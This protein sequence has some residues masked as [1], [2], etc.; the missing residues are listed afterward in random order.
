MARNRRA[1]RARL[2]LLVAL[3]SVLCVGLVGLATGSS[4]A[5]ATAEPTGAISGRVTA[6]PGTDLTSTFVYVWPG[7]SLSA[8]VAWTTAAADGTYVVEGLAPGSYVV[9]FQNGPAGLIGQYWPGKDDYAQ[10]GHVSVDQLPVTGIDAS[11]RMGATITGTIHTNSDCELEY[12]QVAVLASGVISPSAI[13]SGDG[14]WTVTG[15]TSG[16]YWVEFDGSS[17]GLPR[18]LWDGYGPPGGRSLVTLTEGQTTSGI[19]VTLNGPT[20]GCF[21]YPLYVHMVYRDLLDRFADPEG[22]VGWARALEGGTPLWAVANGITGSDEYRG[23]LIDETY[24]RYLGRGAEPAGLAGWL[25]A[26]RSGYHIEQ[27][28]AG[29]IASDEFYVR[30]GSTPTGWVTGLYQTVLLRDPA[31]QEVDAWVAALARGAS[32]TDVAL[33]FLYSSEHLAEVVDGYYVHLLGRHIDATGRAGWVG[34][35]QNGHRDEEIIAGIVA[36]PEYL[37]KVRHQR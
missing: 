4:A 32:R 3:V 24:R 21:A 37:L 29:F 28:Q 19:D 15:L 26:M 25:R 17:V 8:P 27:I 1:R 9:Q 14:R 5:V 6:P 20:S 23:R 31:Q 13:V 11:M 10:A 18:V 36:S 33:G 16:T 34:A 2:E 12:V 30:Y 22:V 7:S 35:I